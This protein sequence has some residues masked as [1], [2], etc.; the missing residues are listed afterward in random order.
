VVSCYSF[1]IFNLEHSKYA[2]ASLYTDDDITSLDYFSFVQTLIL[3]IQKYQKRGIDIEAP[4]E[5]LRYQTLVFCQG[6]LVNGPPPC[7]P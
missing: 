1:S 5:A 6:D 4:R 2:V 3:R 7:A